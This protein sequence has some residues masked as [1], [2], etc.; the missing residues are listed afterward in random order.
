MIAFIQVLPSITILA[1]KTILVIMF[2]NIADKTKPGNDPN[3][4]ANPCT[5]LSICPRWP[6][7]L[8]AYIYIYVNLYIYIYIYMSAY[9]S[10]YTHV[11]FV[12][13]CY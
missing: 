6:K 12:C 4:W 11:H 1:K 7:R 13:R 2:A 5:Y 8:R 9:G 3:I 10:K